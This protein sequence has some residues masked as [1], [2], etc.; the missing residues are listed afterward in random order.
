[1]GRG[2]TACVLVTPVWNDSA[3]LAGFGP[4]LAAALAASGLRVYWIVA[5][6]GSSLMEQDLLVSLV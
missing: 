1:M 5:D 6:D 2:D 4:Q 3:R